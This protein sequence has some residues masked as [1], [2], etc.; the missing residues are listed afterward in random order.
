MPA[1]V[2][3]MSWCAD[4]EFRVTQ[5]GLY[6]GAPG[7]ILTRER[8]VSQEAAA[9]ACIDALMADWTRIVPLHSGDI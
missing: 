2:F 5:A 4:F 3:C 7:A 1:L 8:S 9:A 6:P